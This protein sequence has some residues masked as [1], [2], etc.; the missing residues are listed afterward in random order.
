MPHQSE[1]AAHHQHHPQ[2]ERE[3]LADAQHV[4]L[5]PV[6]GN[7]HRRAAGQAEAHHVQNGEQLAA[8]VGRGNGHVAQLAQHDGVHHVHAQADHILQGNG[9][10]DGQHSLVE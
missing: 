8:Q 10:G 4:P 2:C 9:N 6:L 1:Q 7:Q 3:D 5:A